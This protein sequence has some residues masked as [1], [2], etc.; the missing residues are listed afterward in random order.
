LE[1]IE[2]TEKSIETQR[3]GIKRDQGTVAI[4][5]ADLKDLEAGRLDL[6]EERQ[7]KDEKAKTVSIAVI[8]KVFSENYYSQ[9][10]RN[11]F[12]LV[13]D[14]LGSVTTTGS[15]FTNYV[16]GTYALNSGSVVNISPFYY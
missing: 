9:P 2:E 3:Q 4:L 7:K 8:S 6:I 15:T 12:E 11:T 14:A 16:P 13:S 10:W 1:K 5:R